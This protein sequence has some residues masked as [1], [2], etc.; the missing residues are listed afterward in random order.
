[1]AMT[2]SFSMVGTQRGVHTLAQIVAH[3]IAAQS[4]VLLVSKVPRVQAQENHMQLVSGHASCPAPA[5]RVIG[6][7]CA[8]VQG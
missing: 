2:M 4:L 5:S 6:Y 8:A 1:M 7:P 3:H